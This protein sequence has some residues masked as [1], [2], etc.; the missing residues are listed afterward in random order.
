MPVRNEARLGLHK[1]ILAIGVVE[2]QAAAGQPVDVRRLGRPAVAMLDR[3]AVVRDQQQHVQGPR[4][5]RLGGDFGGR[6]GAAGDREWLGPRIMPRWPLV[7]ARLVAIADVLP[8][9]V[10]ELQKLIHHGR[11]LRGYV[12]RFADVGVEVEQ[13]R[14]GQRRAPELR[15][16]LGHTELPRTASYGLQVTFVVIEVTRLV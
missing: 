2:A 3:A 4:R 9:A 1:R 12:R 6:T 15:A 8:A 14:L 10:N 5:L 13:L 7:L 16:V 11:M